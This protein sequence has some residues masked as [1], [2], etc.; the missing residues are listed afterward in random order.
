[1]EAQRG[2]VMADLRVE[3]QLFCFQSRTF[4]GGRLGWKH[5]DNRKVTNLHTGHTF[6]GFH[7]MIIPSSNTRANVCRLCCHL[8]LHM[9]CSGDG[10]YHPSGHLLLCSFRREWDA[11]CILILAWLKVP[12]YSW[13]NWSLNSTQAT[14]IYRNI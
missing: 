8:L 2:Y 6:P 14:Y 1:M 3:A 13:C 7:P 4:L 9:K 11:W 12:K 10:Q 5:I